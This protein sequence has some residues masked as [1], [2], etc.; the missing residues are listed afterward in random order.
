MSRMYSILLVAI[1]FT[2][3]SVQAQY[4]RKVM[5]EYLTAMTCPPCATAKPIIQG[6]VSTNPRTVAVSYHLDFP[7]PGDPFN[8]FNASENSARQSFYGTTGI[9]DLKFNGQDVGISQ[10]AMAAAVAAVPATSPL[11]ITVSEDRTKNPVAVTITVKND[12]PALSGATLNVMVANYYADLTNDPDVVSNQYK[13][14]TTFDNAMLNILTSTPNGA[15]ITLAQGETKTFNYTYAAST[16]KPQLWNTPYTIAFIQSTSDKQIL[17]AESNFADLSNQVELASTSADYQITARSKT[18]VKKT[19]TLKNSKSVPMEVAL[20]FK[21]NSTLVGAAFTQPTLSKSTVTIPAN[22]TE[23]VD[24]VFDVNQKGGSLYSTV[25]ATP[26]GNGLNIASEYTFGYIAENSKYGLLTGYATNAVADAFASLNAIPKYADELAVVPASQVVFDAFGTVPC[27]GYIL[28]VDFES[29]GAFTDAGLPTLIDGLFTQGKRIMIYGDAAI[30]NAFGTSSPA[31]SRTLFG[32]LGVGSTSAT[33]RFTQNGNTITPQQFTV[34]G[35]QTDELGKMFSGATTLNNFTQT[36]QL[37]QYYTDVMTKTGTGTP[38][39]YYGTNQ[40][41]IAGIR[42]QTQNSRSIVLGFNLIASSN[43]STRRALM[44]NLVD[45]LMGDMVVVNEPDIEITNLE[46]NN[47]EFGEIKVG[48]TKVL[49]ADIKN[50]GSAPLTVT[51][52]DFEASST[53]AAKM[54]SITEGGAFP[55][56]IQP[57][58]THRVGVQF[59]PTAVGEYTGTYNV[60]SNAKSTDS[61][62]ILVGGNAATGSSVELG[63]SADGMLSVN[64]T[65]NPT[66]EVSTINYTVGGTAP[67]RVTIRVIDAVGNTVSTLVNE[68]RTPGTYNAN[69]NAS[70]VSSGTYSVVVS[71]GTSSTFVPVVIVK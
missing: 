67:Q 58:K 12:G 46:N 7:A 2:A 28:P 69:F 17:Q 49:T 62:P 59:K 52:M 13:R 15:P 64:A 34:T 3:V 37:I 51:A 36:Y 39:M 23:S 55:V 44:N 14:Y 63:T 32:K 54:Y 66:R 53:N 38:F 42:N 41:S 35:I 45:W 19:L 50:T 68:M 4:P 9:P 21:Q 16:A 65:P 8:V 20:S 40:S 61:Y 71:A 47:F 29:R 10:A 60:K 5:V 6:F 22:G 30:V 43:A 11:K 70:T 56:T 18:G 48:E 24:V 1:L 25:V 26:T 31:I 27:M 33:A 57:G